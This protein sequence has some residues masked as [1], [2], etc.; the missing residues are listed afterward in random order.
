MN[1]V[2]NRFSSLF[3]SKNKTIGQTQSEGFI[4][5]D[6]MTSRPYPYTEIEVK[7][8]NKIKKRF[9]RIRSNST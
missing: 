3:S 9:S 8:N 2:K 7:Q 5:Y 1:S 4:N 6:E